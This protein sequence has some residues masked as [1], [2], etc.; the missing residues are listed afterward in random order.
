MMGIDEALTEE[1]ENLTAEAEANETILVVEDDTDVRTYLA[2]TLRALKYSVVT[3]SS[4]QNAL[5][6][7]V[8]DVYR[9][10]L[11]LTDV[12]MPGLNGRELGRRAQALRS[13]LPVLYMTG[14]SRNAVVHQGRLDEG[15]ELLQKPVSEQQLASR[16]RAML[17]NART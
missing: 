3:A 2:E 16:I 7:L 10:D 12:V 1:A 4:A 6:I 14:Y 11:M 15:V 17:D 8:Q 13:G 5:M 9:I